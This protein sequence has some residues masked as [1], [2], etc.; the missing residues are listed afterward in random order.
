MKKTAMQQ[1][2]EHFENSINHLHFTMSYLSFF[3]YEKP[4]NQLV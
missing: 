3:N 2:I 4:T 1:L